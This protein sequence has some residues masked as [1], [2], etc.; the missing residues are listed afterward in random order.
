MRILLVGISARRE[1]MG[2][3]LLAVQKH[4]SSTHYRN[5]FATVLEAGEFGTRV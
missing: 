4:L 3:R 2:Q 5:I 1:S